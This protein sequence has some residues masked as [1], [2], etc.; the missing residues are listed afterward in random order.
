MSKSLHR[1][2]SLLAESENLSLNQLIVTMLAKEAGRL[3]VLNRVEDKLDLALNK[4]NDLIEQGE[5]TRVVGI[6]KEP[7]YLI[8]AATGTHFEYPVA[9]VTTSE[10]LWNYQPGYHAKWAPP[11][12]FISSQ[13][14]E[15]EENESE[16]RVELKLE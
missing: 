6:Y 2:L 14:G 5:L 16:N 7:Q 15:E 10:D 8:Q 12:I 9:T 1:A 13:A 11:G 4:I 3:G